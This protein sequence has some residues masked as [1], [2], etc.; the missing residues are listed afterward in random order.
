MNSISWNV[1]DVPPAERFAYWREAVCQS[2]MP[3]EPENLSHNRFDGSIEGIVGTS[4]SISRVR[5]VPAVV[6]RTRR[7]IGTFLDGS[8]YANLQLFGD[9]IVEQSGE[10]AIAHPGDIVLVDTNQP[11]SIRFEHGCDL[12]CATIPD[13]SLRLHL[14]HLARRPNVIR[15]AGAGRLASAYLRTLRELQHDFASVDDLAGD[16]LCALIARAADAQ[17]G[18]TQTPSRRETTLKRIFELIIDELDNPLLSAKFVCRELD[19][20]R[21]TLFS[22]LHDSDITFASHIRA[23]RLERCLAR[24]RDPRLA[25]LGIGEISRRAG[26]A[27]QESFTRAFRRRYG[28][29]P[30][31]Y[32]GKRDI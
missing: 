10:Q 11:F 14:Q 3:L 29:P 17:I 24:I 9:A 1:R 13:G 27:S 31:S 28:A 7:G 15:N 8:F 25:G 21:S 2:F 30:S 6:Q 12:L 32:R 19:I 18:V 16:Q 22:T 23:L 4:L 5:S 26:F 20:S